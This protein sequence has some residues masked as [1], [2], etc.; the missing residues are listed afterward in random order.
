MNYKKA[1]K[2]TEEMEFSR[3]RFAREEKKRA[4]GLTGL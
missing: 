1:G 2:N 4:G 3:A